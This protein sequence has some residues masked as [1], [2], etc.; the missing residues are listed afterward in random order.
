MVHDRYA[1]LT[2]LFCGERTGRLENL[3]SEL[4]N[5]GKVTSAAG[6]DVERFY[7]FIVIRV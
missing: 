5:S 1:Q 3:R 4:P 2:R 7:F 6:L